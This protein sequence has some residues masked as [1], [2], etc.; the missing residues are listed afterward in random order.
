MSAQHSTHPSLPN[1]T[2]ARNAPASPASLALPP[3]RQV[4]LG[5]GSH[6][7]RDHPSAWRE[8]PISWRSASCQAGQEAPG[9]W[10]QPLTLH[11]CTAEKGSPGCAGEQFCTNTPAPAPPAWQGSSSPPWALLEEEEEGEWALLSHQ[12]QHQG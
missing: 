11:R 3:A 12:D 9:A 1:V 5:R 2:L 7:P 8:P 10:L 6:C 4:S